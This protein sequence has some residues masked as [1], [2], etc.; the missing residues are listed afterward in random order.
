MAIENEAKKPP[1]GW[2][3]VAAAIAL[4]CAVLMRGRPRASNDAPM[5][6]RLLRGHPAPD[7]DLAYPPGQHTK[8][9]ALKGKAVLLNFWASWCEPCMEE[10][11]MLVELEGKL[12]DKPFVLLALNA[13]D[14]QP[15]NRAVRRTTMPANLIYDFT[16]SALTSYEVSSIPLSVLIDVQGNVRE[17]FLGP[18]DW[19]SQEMLDVISSATH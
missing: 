4:V 3:L 19:T 7:I 16:K 2:V 13:D 18:R 1:V 15:G 8:L 5:G 14:E 17:V 9:S 6:A 10:M 11:P 12:K